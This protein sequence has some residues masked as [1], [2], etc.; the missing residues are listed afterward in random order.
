MTL[1]KILILYTGGTFGMDILPDPKTKV[2]SFAIPKLSA[3]LLKKRFQ[4]Q[5]PELKSIANCD[6]E[7]I[8]NRDSSHIG[9]DEWVLI[10]DKIRE[11]WKNYDGVVLLHGTDTLAYTAS[12]L[13]FL[14]RPCL[15]PV[16]VTGAQR[17]LSALRTDARN[18]LISAVEIAAHG[19][20]KIVNQVTVFFG[21]K[22]FQGN[23]VRKISAADYSA[24]D[25]PQFPPLAIVG[26]T[27]RYVESPS[28]HASQSHSHL[29]L[30]PHFCK[31]VPVFHLT[32]AFPST[33]I[34]Q[35]LLSHV[36]GIVLVIFHSF[37]APTHDPDFLKFLEKAKKLHIP[38]TLTIEGSSQPPNFVE[39]QP[40]YETS[41]ELL[42]YGCFWAGT[43]TPECAFVKTSLL[44]G[45]ASG[46]KGFA[47]LWKQDLAFEG[48]SSLNVIEDLKA[49]PRQGW[50]IYGPGHNHRS[51]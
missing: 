36:E 29:K 28:H 17:P 8:L 3:D 2:V 43:M 48:S 13:S 18:N 22:L 45:Q 42:S 5:A 1:P 20:R 32:P 50:T 4:Q 40:N 33:A 51:S 21:D 31:N 49:T 24:F 6:V 34:A 10:A 39:S 14:L 41:K 47:K 19:P 9:P 27:I 15:K 37:T 30:L 35:T 44:L 11:N 38:I 16:I 12:A 7:I 46:A 23:R 25:S 26:T